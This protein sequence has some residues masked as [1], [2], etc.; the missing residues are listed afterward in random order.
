MMEN[1]LF[2]DDNTALAPADPNVI[3]LDLESKINLSIHLSWHSSTGDNSTAIC[4]SN[5]TSLSI[6]KAMNSETIL[7]QQSDFRHRIRKLH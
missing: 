7:K 1:P 5:N 6:N 4:Y 2:C 3:V